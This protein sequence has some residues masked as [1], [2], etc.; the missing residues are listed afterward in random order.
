MNNKAFLRGIMFVIIII[1]AITSIIAYIK[2]TKGNLES[3]T[4]KVT[5]ID[6]N[7]TSAIEEISIIPKHPSNITNTSDL[8][9]PNNSIVDN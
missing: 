3:S 7:S 1:F 6:S 9:S 2:F 5:S 8:I 4:G